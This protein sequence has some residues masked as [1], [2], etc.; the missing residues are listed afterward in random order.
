MKKTLFLFLEELKKLNLPKGKY[1]IFGS[2]PLAIRGLRDVRDLDVIVKDDAYE[3]LCA[4]YPR[5]IK[6]EP[7]NCIQ[8]GNLEI[9]NKWLNNSNQID[10]MIETA[11]IIYG[12][13]FVKLKYVLE[14]KKKMGRDK[15]LKDVQLIEKYLQKP[16]K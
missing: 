12:F 4:K 15:D 14:W 9:G 11:D 3:K 6:T 7:V 13:P 1:A 16:K 8:I 2:G 10:E 5:H